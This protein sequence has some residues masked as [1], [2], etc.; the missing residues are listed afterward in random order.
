MAYHIFYS[1]V[2]ARK[3]DVRINQFPK[4]FLLFEDDNIQIP[5][6]TALVLSDEGGE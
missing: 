1:H 6:S 3:Y 2:V 4:R 5:A